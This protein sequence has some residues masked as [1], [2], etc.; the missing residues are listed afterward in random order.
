[1]GCFLVGVLFLSGVIRATVERRPRD[2]SICPGNQITWI[3]K[4]SGQVIGCSPCPACPPGTEYSIPC[5]TKAVNGTP[6][7]CMTCPRG[8]FSNKFDNKPCVACTRCSKRYA[9][10]GCTPH[11]NAVCGGCKA[12]YYDNEISF[13]CEECGRCCHDGKDEAP[14][15]CARVGMCKTRPYGC[16]KLNRTPTKPRM[17]LT[18]KESLASKIFTQQ[19]KKFQRR[20]TNKPRTSSSPSIPFLTKSDKERTH[21]TSQVEQGRS[22]NN[23]RHED[24]AL[25]QTIVLYILLSLLVLI[26]ILLAVAAIKINI[27][28]KRTQ[29]PELVR[30]LSSSYTTNPF[31]PVPTPEDRTLEDFIEKCHDVVESVCVLLGDKQKRG[32]WDFERVAARFGLTQEERIS[33]KNQTTIEGGNATRQLMEVLCSKR[34]KITVKQFAEIVKNINRNDVFDKLQPF[35][36]N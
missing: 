12:G 15:G 20:S 34:P 22:M 23:I 5:S 3:Y 31:M 29:R 33:I 17:N 8:K 24:T 9:K 36:S 4:N 21:F 35:L 6:A 26:L 25:S 2:D 32:M 30:N 28:F 7:K 27:P 13:S 10:K 1:M 19:V 11:G 16:P 18:I 14:L